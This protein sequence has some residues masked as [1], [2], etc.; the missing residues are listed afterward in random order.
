M[1]PAS[2]QATVPPLLKL[3]KDDGKKKPAI[4]KLYDFTNGGTDVT[5]Q[6]I[7]FY[8]S[9]NKSPR[10][11]VNA[12]SY[13][14]DADRVN[15]QNF[16]LSIQMQT[17]ESKGLTHTHGILVKVLCGPQ[18]ERR[19]L[20]VALPK[21]SL[22]EINMMLGDPAPDVMILPET[23]ILPSQKQEVDATCVENQ[24]VVQAILL[25]DRS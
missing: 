24:C 15:S 11:T 7:Q 2:R 19:R 12:F 6:S 1:C 5:D 23:C 8:T 18:M 21:G 20:C 25:R 10:W 22:A 3:T 17:L 4:Y 9:N 14:L 13:I 16:F